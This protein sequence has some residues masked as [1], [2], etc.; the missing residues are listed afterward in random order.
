MDLHSWGW[1]FSNRV[2]GVIETL[3]SA[4]VQIQLGNKH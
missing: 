2:N 1:I 4:E 3:L